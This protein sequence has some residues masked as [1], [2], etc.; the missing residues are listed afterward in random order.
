MEVGSSSG[1]LNGPV[2]LVLEEWELSSSL[3]MERPPVD[4]EAATG[5]DAAATAGCSSSLLFRSN[6]SEG[7]GEKFRLPCLRD[8]LEEPRPP[9]LCFV[10][11]ISTR[12]RR[13]PLFGVE[14]FSLF[15]LRRAMM[16]QRRRVLQRINV[17]YDG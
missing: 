5:T 13:F 16:E 10:A 14:D 7:F 4:M 15:L 9:Y 3:D 2:G 1:V 11:V 12:E 6:V 8:L 17:G